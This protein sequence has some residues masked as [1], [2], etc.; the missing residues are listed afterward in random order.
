MVRPHTFNLIK[1]G[2]MEDGG[3]REPLGET[4]TSSLSKENK[5]TPHIF[6]LFVPVCTC[7][8]AAA[9]GSKRTIQLSSF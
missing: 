7:S 2:G 8:I 1:K 5:K 6:K 9:Q 4:I 3:T